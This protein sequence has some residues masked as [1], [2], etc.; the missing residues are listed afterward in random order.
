MTDQQYFDC[1][2]RLA[3]ELVER[4]ELNK[5]LFYAIFEGKIKPIIKNVFADLSDRF[6]AVDLE[7]L[8][9]DI[10][11][12][13][14]TRCVGAYFMNEKYET[15]APMFLGWCKIVAKNH[16]TSMLR[17][18]SLRAAET[19]D[20]PDH[21]VTVADTSEPISYIEQNDAVRSVFHAVLSLSSKVEL[22]LSWFGV[23]LLVYGGEASDRTEATRLFAKRY[24]GETLGDLF[25]T[26]KSSLLS[27]DRIGIVEAEF[28]HI[29]EELY[30]KDDGRLKKDIMMGEL[31]G[32]DPLG[33]I[34]DWLYKVNKK[35]ANT[36]PAEVIQWNT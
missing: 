2:A 27:A 10:F 18:K 14:W 17:K 6:A 33:K 7:D 29:S 1:Y 9:Q 28:S 32:D 12:K 13:I 3:A 24:A 5:E 35:L 25:L 36:L 21:P 11:I 34:S 23:Y 26:V 30:R 15:S 8:Y 20:D 22:K 31:F 16:V 4:H 19:L